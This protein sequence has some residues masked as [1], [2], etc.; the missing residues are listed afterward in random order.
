MNSA[1]MILARKVGITHNYEAIRCCFPI[2]VSP[3]AAILDFVNFKV[4][5]MRGFLRTFFPILLRYQ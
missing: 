3:M 4:F 1:G 5:P 2:S